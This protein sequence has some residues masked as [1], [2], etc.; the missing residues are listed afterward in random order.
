[1]LYHPYHII[2]NWGISSQL[3][4]LNVAKTEDYTLKYYFETNQLPIIQQL[5]ES[6]TYLIAG[7]SI[8]E[9]VN[10]TSDSSKRFINI[11]TGRVRTVTNYAKMTS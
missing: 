1:L 9:V 2:A 11:N 10:I 4:V 3:L 7:K 6:Y 5:L 8:T